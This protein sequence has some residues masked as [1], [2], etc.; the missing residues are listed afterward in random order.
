MRRGHTTEAISE[1]RTRICAGKPLPWLTCVQALA[2]MFMPGGEHGVKTP[3]SVEV[4]VLSRYSR[5][6]PPAAAAAPLPPTWMCFFIFARLFAGRPNS[7]RC[8]HSASVWFVQRNTKASAPP[9]PPSCMAVFD[10][11]C[12]AVRGIG[13]AAHGA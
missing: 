1:A 12:G 7:M 2:S 4:L 8:K 5:V 6:G 11:A 10:A 9:A 13:G 3:T